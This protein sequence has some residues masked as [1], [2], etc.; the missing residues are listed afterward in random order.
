MTHT[1]HFS[2]YW[3]INTNVLASREKEDRIGV[4]YHPFKLS[5]W[6]V[7]LPVECV[8]FFLFEFVLVSNEQFPNKSWRT[9]IVLTEE[10]QS[11]RASPQRYW[12]PLASEWE[13]QAPPTCLLRLYSSRLHAASHDAFTLTKRKAGNMPHEDT[14]ALAEWPSAVFSGWLI[15]WFQWGST[16]MLLQLHSLNSVSLKCSWYFGNV[17]YIFTVIS[18]KVNVSQVNWFQ[19]STRII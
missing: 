18:K 19:S 7:F 12:A 1:C 3:S 11:Y 6:D 2:K 16:E 13:E 10:P 15:L 4:I 17:Q 14:S 8:S 9:S 5:D